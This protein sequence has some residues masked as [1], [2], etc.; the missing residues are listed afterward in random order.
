ML[1]HIKT[2]KFQ[3]V[4]ELSEREG[5][6]NYTKEEVIRKMKELR[7]LGMRIAVDDIG[8]VIPVYIPLPW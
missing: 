8:K 3:I 4:L 5:L 2:S 6:G 7:E 1:P